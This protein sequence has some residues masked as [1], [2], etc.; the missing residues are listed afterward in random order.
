MRNLKSLTI[1]AAIALTVVSAPRAE[2]QLLN[3]CC[4]P[5]PV[6]CGPV[7]VRR[8]I[9]RNAVTELRLAAHYHLNYRF[10][11]SA[12]YGSSV[13]TDSASPASPTPA[14]VH[15]A[16]KPYHEPSAGQGDSV[17]QPVQPA[18]PLQP[19]QPA[20]P[21]E[22][23]GPAPQDAPPVTPPDQPADEN[24]NQGADED[25]D[26]DAFQIEQPTTA[27]LML[28]V[29]AN[30]VVKIN[31]KA[32]TSTG[33]TRTFV[34]RNLTPTARYRYNIEVSWSDGSS[35][36]KVQEALEVTPGR[37][38]AKTFANPYSSTVVNK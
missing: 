19:V 21:A 10:Y 37:T 34:S 4:R 24:A 1:L 28:T 8:P 6:C 36:Y 14:E 3:P 18:V 5:V 17:L 31:G 9:I 32:T 16:E 2:A 20:Q 23:Q 12:V 35:N 22:P 7:V 27:T 26:E 38:I 13:I 33:A 25:A 11:R 30:A 15:S 29:P